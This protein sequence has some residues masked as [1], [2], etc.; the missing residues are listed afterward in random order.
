MNIS[1][2]V[3]RSLAEHSENLVALLKESDLCEYHLHDET[4]IIVTI[5]GEGISEEIA[6]LKKIQKMDH[7][8]S[9]DMMYSYSEDE[10]DR[11][12]DKIEKSDGINQ[13][14]NDKS[15]DAGLINYAGDL[16]KKI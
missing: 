11:E 6:K 13:W 12:K 14:L 8:I 2:I 15:K 9:A 16:K 1:S 3:I 10:L 4:K 5:E 7:V